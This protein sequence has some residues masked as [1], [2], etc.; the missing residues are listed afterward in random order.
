MRGSTAM[1]R[2]SGTHR[3]PI[4]PN[5]KTATLVGLTAAGAAMASPVVFSGTAH[6]ASSNTWDRVAECES[7]QRWNINTGNGYY[8]GLQ[9]SPSTW[10]GFGGTKYAPQAHLA[11]RGQQILIAE[12]VLAV[13]GPNAWPVCSKR[14]GLTRGGEAPN[15]SAGESRSNE[16]TIRSSRSEKRDAAP[17]EDTAPRVAPK[18][19]PATVTTQEVSS[20]AKKYAKQTTGSYQVKPGDSLSKIAAREDLKGGWQAL[21]FKN[22]NVIGANP[23]YI[24][25]GLK[26]SLPG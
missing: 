8:G 14:A 7:G 24:T 21:W 6:A 20:L 26:F 5:R 25:V 1:P 2:Y 15:V 10:R 22:R 19:V 23:D 4:T 12:K 3:T 9:F 11:T 18:P 13:Q 17:R 16:R